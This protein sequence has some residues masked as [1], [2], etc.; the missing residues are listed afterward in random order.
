MPV[1]NG[2]T[3]WNVWLGR[4]ALMWRWNMSVREALHTYTMRRLGDGRGYA[5]V[6]PLIV[7]WCPS[8]RVASN[9]CKP[10]HWN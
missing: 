3:T 7:E 8:S 10:E 2:L 9:F 6:G 5:T 1:R 4:I